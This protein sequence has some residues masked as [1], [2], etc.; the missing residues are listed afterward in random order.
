MCR[1]LATAAAL[2]FLGVACVSMAA[3]S[4]S[5]RVS[6][7]QGQVIVGLYTGSIR[8]V[9]VANTNTLLSFD[10]ACTG[11]STVRPEPA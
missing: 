5:G 8:A 7:L 3:I 2:L 11:K 6:L 1:Q 10:K 4:Y 9:H